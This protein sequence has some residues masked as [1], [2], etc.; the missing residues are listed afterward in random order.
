MAAGVLEAARDAYAR[1]AWTRADHL[2]RRAAEAAPLIPADVE[3]LAVAAY[4]LGFDDRRIDALAQ[5]HEGHLRD[6]DRL[7]AVRVAFWLVVHLALCGEIGRATGWRGRA[8]RLVEPGDGDCPE[9]GYLASADSLCS[10]VAGDWAAMRAAAAEAVAVGERFG[11]RDLVALGLIDLGR[12]M[13]EEGDVADGLGALDEAMLAAAADELSPVATGFVYCS[14]I[15]GCHLTYELERAG[16]W[17][18]ALT[19]WCEQ[20]PDLVPFTGTCLIHRAEILQVRGALDEAFA[21]ARR[22][23]ERLAERRGAR[24]AGES[25]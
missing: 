6:G 22:A 16:E 5:A 23:R 2:F 9:R 10:M 17:T 19:E 20:Q 4:M 25:C 15:E 7:G 21:H 12:A 18:L 24:A 13:I 8:H 3:R 1:R 14:V 11:D